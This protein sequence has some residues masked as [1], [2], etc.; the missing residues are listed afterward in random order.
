MWVSK[1][2]VIP[3]NG[4]LMK[5][6]NVE[7]NCTVLPSLQ[8]KTCFAN[9]SPPT[10]NAVRNEIIIAFLGPL[11]GAVVSVTLGYFTSKKCRKSRDNSTGP[12]RYGS[13]GETPLANSLSNPA[14][15]E[16]APGTDN[17]QEDES[18]PVDTRHLIFHSTV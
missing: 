17:R 6:Q 18:E 13:T 11:V 14:V 5:V 4:L 9:E 2:N 10:S 3:V 1:Q 16:P 8:D 12:D 7:P 15:E